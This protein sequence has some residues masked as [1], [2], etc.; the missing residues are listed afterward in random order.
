MGADTLILGDFQNI[1]ETISS[2]NFCTYCG[3]PVEDNYPVGAL[4]LALLLFPIGIIPCWLLKVDPLICWLY[5]CYDMLMLIIL[6]IDVTICWFMLIFQH[7]EILMCWIYWL[8]WLI[9]LTGSDVLIILIADYYID[10]RCYDMLI[11]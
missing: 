9:I 6:I 5:F 10:D 3:W 2:R 4:C 7:A 11:S 8:Y 1:I